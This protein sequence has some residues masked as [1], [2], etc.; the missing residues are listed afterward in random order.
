MS[1]T[2]YSLFYISVPRFNTYGEH[3]KVDAMKTLTNGKNQVVNILMRNCSFWTL[4]L[5]AIILQ[6][7]FT[8]MWKGKKVLRTGV[9]DCLSRSQKGVQSDSNNWDGIIPLSVPERFWR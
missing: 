8:D 2:I 3:F 6:Q 7:L 9:K 4:E 1:V 5:S